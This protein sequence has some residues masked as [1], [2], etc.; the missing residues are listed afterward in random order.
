M[1]CEEGMTTTKTRSALS[2]P[3]NTKQTPL[4]KT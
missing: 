1:L 4:V 3:Q 2:V